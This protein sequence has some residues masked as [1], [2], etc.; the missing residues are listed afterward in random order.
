MGLGCQTG[1]ADAHSAQ[2]ALST[3]FWGYEG[4]LAI[5]RS[6]I[7]HR[8]WGHRETLRGR[9]TQR[10]T[11][12]V[13]GPIEAGLVHPGPCV[14]HWWVELPLDLGRLLLVA[15]PEGR[16]LRT[17]PSVGRWLWVHH[18]PTA[19]SRRPMAGAVG[20]PRPVGGQPPLP[21]CCHASTSRRWLFER[22]SLIFPTPQDDSGCL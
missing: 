13:R 5:P 18:Q 6:A 22:P 19:V 2:L 12:A 8:R 21:I 3:K 7:A 9:H 10:P 16:P 20:R 17:A 11:L 14:G 4:T 15:Q 1:R